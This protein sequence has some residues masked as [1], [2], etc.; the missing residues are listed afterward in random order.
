L[1]DSYE[2]LYNRA[3]MAYREGNIPDAIDLYRRLVGK[4]GRLSDRILARRPE[5]GD[6]H[7]QARLELTGILAGEGRYAEAIEVEE[8]LLETHSDEVDT[9]RRDLA[10]LRISKGEV[11]TG[12]AEL[13]A[14]AEEAPDD[15]GRWTTFAREAHIEGRFAESQ[16][17]IDRALD[18]CTDD[19]PEELAEAH[20][21]QFRLYKKMGRQ[22]DAIAAWEVALEWDDT[23]GESIAE[24]Y[25]ML[26][27]VGR[28]SDALRYV[29]RDENDLQAGFQR[30][31]IASLTGSPTKAQEEWEDV[32]GID[33]AEFDYGHDAWVEAVL[34]LGDPD[35]ALEWLQE[36]LPRFGTPRLLIL[37]GI[38][39]AMRQDIELASGLFQQAITLLR[40]GRP[41]KQ[42]LDSADWRLLDSLVTDDEIKAS[43][44]PYFAVLEMVWG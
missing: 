27:K 38:A 33:A 30:G 15:A 1:R 42:K 13:Q 43:L 21:E 20:F 26:T 23:V 37:S 19:E 8:V 2:G 41:P 40:R 44:K 39:W 4:L 9:W 29:E 22:D 10:V 7:R 24:V 6:M 14:L 35:P 5:L 11:D 25:T 31:L 32:V 3:Q 34:R 12:L 36:Y 18:A 16:V 17:A 28:Y